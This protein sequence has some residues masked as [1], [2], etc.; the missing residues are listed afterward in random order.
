MQNSA[1]NTNEFP[2][3]AKFVAWIE[4]HVYA[5]ALLSLT[6][7]CYTFFIVFFQS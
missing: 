3:K 1:I 5:F 6:V 7:S 2:S 4:D